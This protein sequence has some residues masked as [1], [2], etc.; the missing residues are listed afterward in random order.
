MKFS[1][2]L[3]LSLAAAF[4][5]CLAPQ[6]CAAQSTISESPS[7]SSNANAGA[8]L[9]SEREDAQQ[10]VPA[11]ASLTR[12]IDAQMDQSGSAI[13]A[14]LDGTV[15]LKNGTELPNGTMLVGRVTTDKMRSDGVSRLALRF[16]EAKLQDGHAVPIEATIVDI[17]GPA[18]LTENVA[19]FDGPLRWNGRFLQYEDIGVLSRVDLHSRIGGINSGTLV[20]TDKSDMRLNAGSRMS[21]ALGGLG[22]KTID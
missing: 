11:E 18:A 10:L 15:H 17:S 5:V 1:N 16:T 7:A 14:R 8:Q 4:A 19:T 9:A 22:E 6:F 2:N 12:S 20:A 13:G 21:L 3:A